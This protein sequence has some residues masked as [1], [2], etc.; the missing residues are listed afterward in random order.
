MN[1]KGFT[2]VELIIVMIIITILS[3]TFFGGFFVSEDVAIRALKAHGFSDI[4]IL[5]KDVFLVYFRGCSNTDC[6]KFDI[7]AKNPLGETVELYV[8][9]GWL[10][11][12]AT[13]RTK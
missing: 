12:G 11:K 1:N 2:L 9:S 5:D 4:E 8:C 3:F 10:F 6:A 7:R 13:V